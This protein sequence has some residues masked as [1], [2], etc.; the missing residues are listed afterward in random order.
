MNSKQPLKR[1]INITNYITDRF[2]LI[3]YKTMP[4]NWIMNN[5]D[6]NHVLVYIIPLL[7]ILQF[8]ILFYICMLPWVTVFSL[9]I[10]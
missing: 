6:A 4:N 8:T 2:R 5:H 1:S 3:I 7:Q 10:F 9:N